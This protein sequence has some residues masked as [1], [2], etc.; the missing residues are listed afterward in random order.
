MNQNFHLIINP[1]RFPWF[2]KELGKL[3]RYVRGGTIVESRDADHFRELIR[4]FVASGDSYLLIWGGDGTA[5]LALNALMEE[6]DDERRSQI[7]VGFLR[8]GSG[9]GIQ[10]SYEVPK[11]LSAQVK[12]YLRSMRE[13]LTQRVDL[14]RVEYDG[15][16]RYGQLFGSGLDA[17]ILKERNN[18]KHF[19]GDKAPRAGFFPYITAAVRVVWNEARLRNQPEIIRMKEGRFAFRGTRTNAEFPFD[20][21][22]ISSRAPLIEAGVRPY[23]GWYYKICPDVVCNDGFFDAYLFNVTTPFT[24]GFHL[25]YLW[26]GLYNRINQWQ[27]KR[28]LPLIEHYKIKEMILKAEKGRL[29]HIDGELKKSDGDIKIQVVPKAMKFLVPTSFHEKFHPIHEHV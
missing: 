19:T 4:Q 15:K 13:N 10:D 11:G 2:S 9:N 29:F 8:G 17:K 25:F 14:I 5:N 28:S 27:A 22:E 18:N 20:R 21:Y 3:M 24:V 12:T 26:N 16:E 1:G 7:A 23:F 6:A